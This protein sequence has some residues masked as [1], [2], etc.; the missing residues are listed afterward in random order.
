MSKRTQTAM[1]K[2]NK[3]QKTSNELEYYQPQ[4]D[5]ADRERLLQLWRTNIAV[6]EN[7]HV[8]AFVGDRFRR[9][10]VEADVELLKAG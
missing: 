10:L 6:G 3:V 7:A 4:K 2:V 8:E 1:N 5:L 9:R